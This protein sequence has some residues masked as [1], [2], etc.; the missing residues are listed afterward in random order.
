VIV[1]APPERERDVTAIDLDALIRQALD[2]LSVKEAVAEIAAVTGTP[3]REVYQRALA[4]TKEHGH[5][6]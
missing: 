4:L 2:R 3:R 5:G 1:V 6:R